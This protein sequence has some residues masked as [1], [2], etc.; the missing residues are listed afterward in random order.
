MDDLE[1]NFDKDSQSIEIQRN[2]ESLETQRRDLWIRMLVAVSN[3][4]RVS[5][6]STAQNWADKAVESFDKRFK[7]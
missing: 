1:V 4:T 7:V 2:K 3:D 5:N 6:F